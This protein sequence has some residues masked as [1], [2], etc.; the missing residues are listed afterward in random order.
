MILPESRSLEWIKQAAADNHTSNPILVEKVIRAFSLL[1]ALARSGCPFVFKGGS[2]LMLHFGSSRRLSIDIDII[3]PPGTDIEQYWGKYAKDYGFTLVE[4]VDRIYRSNVPKTHAKCHYQVSYKTNTDVDTILLDVLMEDNNYHEVES[5]PIRSPFLLT[6]GPDVHVSIPCKADL[7]GD[8]LTAFAPHTTGIPFYKGTRNCSMEI[9]KQ[10]YDIA[11]LLDVTDNL[12]WTAETYRKLGVLEMDYRR[13]EG[14]D[15]SSVAEDT[16]ATA[17]CISTNGFGHEEDFLFYSDGITRVRNFIHSERYNM[18]CAVRD[19]SKAAYAAACALNNVVT[20]ERYGTEAL[21][22][23][24]SVKIPSSFAT[25][26]NQLRIQNP[27]A[28][29]YWY[30][31]SEL[32]R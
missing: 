22:S 29:F 14:R 20:P 25:H 4:A 18:S 31:T 19:A 1:E 23:L 26:L 27:E 8:K 10:M 2:S 21:A 3:C 13:M 16:I 7:L 15:I 6:E 9:M 28:F 32:M 12:A 17:L 5:L 11:S 24:A 30:K